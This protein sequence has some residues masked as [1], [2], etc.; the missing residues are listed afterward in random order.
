[1]TIMLQKRLLFSFCLIFLTVSFT[2]CDNEQ[3]KTKGETKG[4]K[5][6][7][8]SKPLTP[9]SKEA[10]KWGKFEGLMSSCQGSPLNLALPVNR[11]AVNISKDSLQY[12]V[13]PFSD[14]SGIFHRFLDSLEVRCPDKKY[15][16]PEQYRSSRDLARWYHE[17]AKLIRVKDPLSMMKYI[18]PGSVMFYGGKG[19]ANKEIKLEDLFEHGGINHVGVVTEVKQNKEGVI[20]GYSLFHGQRPGKLASTTNYHQRAYRNRPNYPAYGNGTEAWVAV[21][22]LI[23]TDGAVFG[24]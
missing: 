1:M 18:R 7:E 22:P 8:V 5:M 9:A 16:N 10:Q 19:V 14:C 13:E 4:D 11:I 3:E 23:E 6:G 12:D 2:A 21:A 24:K 20:T 17:K 15:P